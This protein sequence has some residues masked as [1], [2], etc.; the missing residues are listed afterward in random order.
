[1]PIISLSEPNLR[2]GIILLCG[3]VHDAVIPA[4]VQAGENNAGAYGVEAD[5]LL[6]IVHCHGAGKLDNA[7][8]WWRCRGHSARRPAPSC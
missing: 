3:L 6:N 7:G 2:M 1:M 8:A 4:V 5:V